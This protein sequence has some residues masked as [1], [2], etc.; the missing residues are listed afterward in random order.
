M[1]LPSSVTKIRTK[2]GQ[3]SVEFISNVDQVNYTMEELVKAALR[4]VKKYVLKMGRNTI[5]ANLNVVTGRLYKGFQGWV[6]REPKTGAFLQIG[7]KKD[8]GAWYGMYQEF[9]SQNV[10]KI[11]AIESS[12]KDNIDMIR[13]IESQYLSAL[14][15]ES[16][17]SLIDESED[18]PDAD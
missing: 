1:P 10:P 11:G 18:S 13:Q 5:K 14:S 2:Q 15:S 6:R 3:S 7:I 16:A 8:S 17:P 9:G 12:V 4:D